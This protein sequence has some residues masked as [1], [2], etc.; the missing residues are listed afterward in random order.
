M[1][2]GADTKSLQATHQPLNPLTIIKMPASRKSRIYK[3]SAG[4]TKCR[5]TMN[6]DKTM[7]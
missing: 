2:P 3:F 4:R 5:S 1:G 6:E 7:V